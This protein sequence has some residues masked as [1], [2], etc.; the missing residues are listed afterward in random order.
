MICGRSRFPCS[1]I[2]L[3]SMMHRMG[4]AASH[5]LNL[6][7]DSYPAHDLYCLFFVMTMQTR[8]FDSCNLTKKG[9]LWILHKYIIIIYLLLVHQDITGL[10]DLALALRVMVCHTLPDHYNVSYKHFLIAAWSDPSLTCN[11]LS[12]LV[13]YINAVLYWNGCYLISSKHTEWSKIN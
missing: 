6:W 11:G 7:E 5:T 3:C 2:C 10:Y 1:A 12:L 8:P 13:L 4:S 9:A